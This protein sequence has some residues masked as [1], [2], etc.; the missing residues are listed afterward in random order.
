MTN[1]VPHN[2][3]LI[4]KPSVK[5]V[6]MTQ[7]SPTALRE[8]SNDN[9]YSELISS[10]QKRNDNPL[11]RIYNQSENYGEN[12]LHDPAVIAEF[13]GRFC[14]R[15]FSKGRGTQ[16]YLMNI[17]EMSHGSVLEHV[18][19]TFTIAGVSRSLSHE[20]VRHRAG[21]A[22]SQESQ[23]YVDAKDIKFVVPP[24]LRDAEPAVLELFEKSCMESLSSYINWQKRFQDK[25]ADKLNVSIDSATVKQRTIIKKRA[26]EAARCFLPNA[27]E[28]RLTWTANLRALRHVLEMRGGGG[29]DLEIRELAFEMLQLVLQH[30]PMGFL[31]FM[32]DRDEFGVTVSPNFSKV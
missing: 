12:D 31:D 20:L 1:E 17:L 5:I 9:G 4:L 8:W 22:I 7:I 29:A 24:L 32:V 27:A 14:Y 23:R 16:E 21:T 2:S 15:S 28:T 10:E 25:V 3:L 30:A 13:G 26:N 18:N 11:G 19:Y 6:A